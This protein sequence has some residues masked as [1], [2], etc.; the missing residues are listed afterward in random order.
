MV[1]DPLR[2]IGEIKVDIH[3]PSTK[4]YTD[5]EKDIRT[6]RFDLSCLFEFKRKRT[7]TVTFNWP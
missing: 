2:R 6:S 1:A 3:F 7:K 4:T 5:K